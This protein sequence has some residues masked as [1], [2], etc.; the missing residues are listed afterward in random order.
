MA[1]ALAF[2]AIGLAGNGIGRYGSAGLPDTTAQ[3]NGKLVGIPETMFLAGGTFHTS[4]QWDFYAFG[5]GEYENAKTFTGTTSA[6][7]FGY[8][9]LPG[10]NNSG[11]IIEG[12]ACAA[13]TKSIDQATFGFWDKFYQGKFGRF[14][15]GVQY[16]YT[17]KRGFADAATGFAPKAT[18]NMIFT[19]F[20]FYP[21]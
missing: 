1:A 17:E 4:P 15:F 19:S 7:A 10:S 18:K 14:Q 5:G 13:V 20:R 2:C 9:T 11:C 6:V 16:S 3:P 21:F 8:G 12:G